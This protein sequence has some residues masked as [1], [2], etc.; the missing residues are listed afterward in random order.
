MEVFMNLVSIPSYNRLKSKKYFLGDDIPEAP[1]R[2]MTD[3]IGKVIMLYGSQQ[4]SNHFICHEI[5]KT[6]E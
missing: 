3:K 6:I 5:R 2:K 1:E 4:R